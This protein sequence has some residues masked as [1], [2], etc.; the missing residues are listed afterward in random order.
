MKAW[1]KG[2]LISAIIFLV[3]FLVLGI[4]KIFLSDVAVSNFFS[5]LLFRAVF[6]LIIGFFVGLIIKSWEGRNYFLK[7][8]L[9]I[10]LIALYVWN[11]SGLIIGLESVFMLFILPVVYI[12][13]GL[14]L[15][16]GEFCSGNLVVFLV[17]FV[18]EIVIIAFI[19]GLVIWK[20]KSRK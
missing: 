20:V 4:P 3:I 8:I 10:L 12:L 7:T 5:V 6:A 16:S 2:G 19:I 9:V 15:C 11:G 1:L 17:S 18:I 14:G 13:G